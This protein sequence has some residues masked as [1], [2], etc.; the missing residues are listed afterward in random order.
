MGTSTPAQ[1]AAK[2]RRLSQLMPPTAHEI[3]NRS[4][5]VVKLSVQARLL[6]AAPRGRLNVGKRGQR[7]GVRYKV[8]TDTA[9][10]FMFGPAQLIERDTKAHRIPNATKGRGRVKRANRKPI[11]IPGVGWRQFADHPGTKGKHPWEKG[12]ESALPELVK[13]S[14]QL[15]GEALRK[16][17]R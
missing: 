10:V 5:F 17:M 2:M 6:V 7:I 8:D 14:G 1:F 9:T 15:Y 16:A 11:N 12:V 4:A 13:V 3:V